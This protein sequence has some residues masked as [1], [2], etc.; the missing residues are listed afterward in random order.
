MEHFP[1]AEYVLVEAQAVHQAALERFAGQF[2]NARYVLSAAADTIGEIYFDEAD[3]FGGLASHSAFEDNCTRVPCTTIDA[4]VTNLDLK[5]PFCIKLD[6]HGFEVPILDGARLTM[7]STALIVIECYNFRLPGACLL[8]EM[9]DLLGNRGF[10]CV[11]IVDQMYRPGDGALWQADLFFLQASDPAFLSS[12]YTPAL[13]TA[14]C[15][16]SQ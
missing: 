5:G 6:T 13:V 15:G 10:R 2:P 8:H 7:G 12:S 1:K 4:I 16:Q 3:P 9:M 14:R 11:D